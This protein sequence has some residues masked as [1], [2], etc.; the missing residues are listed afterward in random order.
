MGR[1]GSEGRDRGVDPVDDGHGH[2][3]G[4]DPEDVREM[5]ACESCGC[6]NPDAW[7]GLKTCD[8]CSQGEL[9]AALRELEQLNDWADALERGLSR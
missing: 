8:E 4:G 2:G 7:L 3:A 9:L 5:M 6:P 1:P